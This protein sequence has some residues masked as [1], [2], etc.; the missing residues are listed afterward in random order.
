[1]HPARAFA[2]PALFFLGCTL[3]LAA[4]GGA[5]GDVDGGRI[6]GI[7]AA[8][9]AEDTGA[10]MDDAGGG[11]TDDTGVAADDTGGASMDDAGTGPTDD[12]GTVPTDAGAS[13][14]A[15]PDAPR[16]SMPCTAAG[17]CDPFDPMA[18]GAGMACRG[19]AMGAPTACAMTAATTVGEGATCTA[20][21][22][23]AGGTACLDFGSGLRCNRLCPMGSIGACGAGAVCTGT[24]TGGDPCIMVC[25]ALPTRCDIYAQDCADPLQACTLV[26]NPETDERYTGCR[27]AGTRTDGQPCGG[28]SGS[29]ARGLVCISDGSG[30]SAC[31]HVCEAAAMP[32]TCPAGQACTGTTRG[33]GVTYCRAAM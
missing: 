7:D 14:D 25:R 26:S 10:A 12:A 4:C 13:L 30:T 28:T 1:M 24:I 20:S 17:A 21:N 11:P 8:L 23:C 6:R 32:T 27:T 9:P 16:V 29:C 19:G 15:G 18:C 22:Q 5:E 31:H 2:P 33:W 3:A